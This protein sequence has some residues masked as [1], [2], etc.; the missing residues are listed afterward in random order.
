MAKG[1]GN[2]G[3]TAPKKPQNPAVGAGNPAK[4]KHKAGIAA[5][6]VPGSGSGKK[7]GA[8][9]GE[10][11]NPGVEN[12]TLTPFMTAEDIMD[13]SNARSEYERQIHELD[14]GYEKSVADTGYEK[15]NITKAARQQSADSSDDFAARGLQ[16]SS[17]RDADMFD[18]DATAE[19]KKAFLDTNLNTLKLHTDTEKER[20]RSAWE[21]PETGFLHGMDLK[22][23]QNAQ[24]ASADAGQ[25]AVEPGWT[26]TPGADAAK[27][28][29]PAKKGPGFKAG[30]TITQPSGYTPPPTKTGG[31][32][33]PNGSKKTSHVNAARAIMGRQ[34][35]T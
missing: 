10:T 33:A 1:K 9:A 23:V 13:Y 25:Y 15:G 11:W 20:L 18:I 26:K 29:K 31:T 5:G 6:K 14:Y 17:V 12:P 28:K 3:T 34:Y 2:G 32:Q 19:M 27:G 8:H 35:Y 7:P 16:R 4:P 22:K 30:S 24:A 21:D